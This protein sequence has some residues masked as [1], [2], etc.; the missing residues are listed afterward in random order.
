MSSSEY[1]IKLDANRSSEFSAVERAFYYVVRLLAKMDESCA[2]GKPIVAP[3]AIVW[4]IE[5]LKPTLVTPL[6]ETGRTDNL[7]ELLRHYVSLRD[8]AEKLRV[9]AFYSACEECGIHEV[10]WGHLTVEDALY[11]MAK[12]KW[13]C[14]DT[15]A[16]DS[17][18]LVL[19]TAIERHK[20]DRA[21]RHAKQTLSVPCLFDVPCSGNPEFGAPDSLDPDTS[22]TLKI[23]LRHARQQLLAS[24]N[25]YDPE[26]WGKIYTAVLGD[27]LEE[28]LPDV[29]AGIVATGAVS[30]YFNHVWSYVKQMQAVETLWV[31]ISYPIRALLR[32]VQT[33]SEALQV[34]EQFVLQAGKS[35]T[36]VAAWTHRVWDMV[37]RRDLVQEQSAS[38]MTCS[39]DWNADVDH[40]RTAFRGGSTCYVIDADALP[41]GLRPL[42]D[43]NSVLAVRLPE[44]WLRAEH[45]LSTP[46]NLE[47]FYWTDSSTEDTDLT[48]SINRSFWCSDEYLWTQLFRFRRSIPVL[49]VF[50]GKSV[51]VRYR[52]NHFSDLRAVSDVPRKHL[53]TL[54][55]SDTR[56]KNDRL[57]ELRMS[58]VI[59]GITTKPAI[60][61]NLVDRSKVLANK[62][63]R[64]AYVSE[65]PGA[66]KG[67]VERLVG[68]W[69]N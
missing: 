46:A 2:P 11:G 21:D 24:D 43:E 65:N 63:L 57:A 7:I 27:W 58:T 61:T 19:H 68:G 16:R 5:K 6:R 15:A 55:I 62:S 34:I 3:D 33:E 45:I 8:V 29:A 26:F 9:D 44:R 66:D 1:T 35:D 49:F 47:R 42:T 60:F 40:I 17:I 22:P 67:L 32:A 13:K 52:F 36:E 10:D 30:P 4:A 18:S 23:A 41:Q 31:G 64:K 14:N 50:K 37:K 56:W 48:L 69:F 28:D 59:D 12:G 53:P 54:E 25:G 39:D 51:L 38:A 20:D